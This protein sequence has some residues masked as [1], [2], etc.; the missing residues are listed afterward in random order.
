MCCPT[1]PRSPRTHQPPLHSIITPRLTTRR[2]NQRRLRNQSICTPQPEICY[3]YGT[4]INTAKD[5]NTLRILLH[6]P[7]GITYSESGEDFAYVHECLSELAVDVAGMPETKLNWNLPTVSAKFQ[8]TGCKQHGASKIATSQYQIPLSTEVSSFQAGGTVTATMGAWATRASTSQSDPS[9]LGRWSSQTFNGKGEKR[10]TVITAYRV[11]DQSPGSAAL[12]S[13]FLREWHHWRDHGPGNRKSDPRERCI[14]DL[15]TFIQAKSLH[16]DHEVL[17]ML[18]ANETLDSGKSCG[19]QHLVETCG[20]FD[21]QAD[22]PAPSTFQHA[23]KRRIDF[24]LGTTGIKNALRASG[25]L[26]FT[27]GLASDHRALFVDLCALTLLSSTPSLIESSST[28]AL[29]SGNPAKVDKYNEEMTKYYEDHKIF[30]RMTR[31]KQQSTRMSR[32]QVRRRLNALDRDMG[33][34]MLHAEN[35]LRVPPRKYAWSPELRKAGL[36]LRYWKSCLADFYQE[37]DSH[38]THASIQQRLQQHDRRYQLPS[39]DDMDDVEIR[40]EISQACAELRKIRATHLES[41]FKNLDEL[42][43]EYESDNDPLTQEASA[44]KA[45]IVRNTIRTEKT[46][47]MFRKI[48]HAVKPKQSGGIAKVLIPHHPD[49]EKDAELT[50]S[51]VMDSGVNVKALSWEHVTDAGAMER[52]LLDYNREHF[53][54]AAVSP[55]GH[56]VIHDALTYSGLSDAGD[57]IL[58]GEIPPEWN[59]EDGLLRSFLASFAIP[60]N[61]KGKR[62]IKSTITAEDFKYGISGWQ[63]STSTSPSGRHLGHYKSIVQD[64]K[65]LSVQVKMMNIAIKKGIALDRWCKSVTVMIEKD[66]GVPK[67]HRIRVIHLYEAD[68]NLFLKLQWGSR[69]VKHGEKHKGLND[70]NFGSRKDRTAMEPV[71]L[72][73]LSYDLSHQSR[74][75]L[76]TFDNDASACYD[77]IIVA[78]AM[79]AARRLRMPRN[80]VQTHAEALRMMRYYVKTVHGISEDCYKGTVF[81]PLFGTGQGSGASPAA[82]LTLISI[83]LNTIDRELPDDRMTF[84]DPLTKKPHSRLADAYVDDTMLGKSDSGDLSYEDLIGRLQL[85]AQTWERLLSYSGGA[86]NLSKCFYYVLYWEWPEGLPVLRKS[87]PEDPTIVLTS[88]SSTSVSI[89]ERLD[90]NT[91]CRTLGVFLSPTSDWTTQIKVLKAKMDL[92][93]GRLLTSSLSF[94]DVRVFYQSIYIPTIRYVLPALSVEEKQL[95][96]IQTRSI[97]ALLIRKGFNRHFPRRITHGPQSWG[98]LGILDIKTEGGLSQIKELRHALYG[99]SEPGKLMMYSLKYSQIESGLGFHLLEDPTVFISWLTPTW[100]MSLRAFLFNHNITITLTDCW[101]FPLCCQHDQYLMEPA[102]TDKSFTPSEYEH[103]NNVRMHLQ[104][105]TLSDISDGNGQTVNANIMLGRRP[106]DRL[107][108]RAW[109][110]QPSVTAYQVKLWGRYLRTHFVTDEGLHFRQSLGKWTRESNLDWRYT[111]SPTNVLF[112]TTLRLQAVPVRS[113]RSTRRAT[114]FGAWRHAPRITTFSTP[115]TVSSPYPLTATSRGT[116]VQVPPPIPTPT[117]FAAHLLLQPPGPRRLLQKFDQHVSDTCMIAHLRSI[118]SKT[119]STDG[120]LSLIGQGTFGWMLTDAQ[121]KKLVTGSGPVDGPADQSSSTRSELHGFAAPL[122]YIHQLARY[123]S[124]RLKGE[125]EW[126]CDSQCAL[127]RIGVLLKFQQRRRQPYNADIISNLTHRLGQNRTMNIKRTWVQA[128]QDEKKLP[129]EILSDAALRNIKVDSIAEDYLH[130]PR[131]PQTSD[132]AA[133]VDAQA[134]SIC[135][136]GTRVTGRYEDAIRESIDGSYLREYLSDKHAWSDSTWACIDWYSHERHLKVLNGASL[137]Q[138]LKFI[139]DWQC[140]NSQKFKFTKSDDASIGLCPCCKTTPEDHD[141]VLRCPSQASTRYLELQDIRGSIEQTTSPAGP[142]LWAGLAHWLNHPNEP[143]SIDTSRYSGDTQ[144]LVQQALREQERIGWDKAFRG[145]LSLTWGL[146]ENPHNVPNPYNKNPQP[147]AWVISTLS[148]LGNFSHAMWKDR[149]TK[150][151]DPNNTSSPTA[152]LDAEIALCYA[153]PQDLLAADR[154]LLHKPIS[155]VLK[156]RRPAKTKFL[157]GI[158]RAHRRFIKERLE[159]QY[160]IRH[161]FEPSVPSPAP[162]DPDPDPDPPLRVP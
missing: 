146:L 100:I 144:L 32:K 62:D 53:R 76:A 4:P 78:L 10:L 159:R 139:H 80:A 64:A 121:G 36:L 137:Y 1:G 63:E 117:S 82:W 68:Y 6:N 28:R 79:L 157:R 152:D 81:E 105:A 59:V 111:Q 41:R 73:H 58:R 45:N 106:D 54:K 90:P 130:D 67:I 148:K 52:H 134:V 50:P 75:N 108:S 56:G 155:K 44:R 110:R 20:M 29:N 156:S 17:L 103:I 18:D 129:G 74:T 154:Q 37:S 107:S 19:I 99:D 102:L 142:V 51:Q 27:E 23:A 161:F 38:R 125:F 33:R 95:E 158:R 14:K 2:L 85:I 135:I 131:Q 126:E 48:G 147:S 5:P 24:M 133:H 101:H 93:A 119:I 141:H 35:Q 11:V 136:Q 151:H 138:R 92:L 132:N 31:L 124:M 97:E 98:G 60:E 43:T 55:C 162:P 115:A 46:R 128:H 25:T 70:Q 91:A 122:E 13:T 123:Y 77:R 22:D 89:I 40:Q 94:D 145:Y 65:L 113:A 57:S 8:Q 143:L 153:N 47:T 149:C 15:I 9:G 72:K 42:L 112:D 69:L 109:P 140:T 7:N 39:A 84:L 127:N 12:G 96:E 66:I 114:P 88:G 83:L 26:S 16:P 160:S 21:L 86:L 3:S 49:P 71:L 150:L 120:G 104:V 30:D 34:A 118:K 116:T 87:S 61:L